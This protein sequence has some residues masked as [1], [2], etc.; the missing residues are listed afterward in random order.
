LA[1]FTFDVAAHAAGGPTGPHV[2]CQLGSLT[3]QTAPA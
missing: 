1:Y 3:D 2:K